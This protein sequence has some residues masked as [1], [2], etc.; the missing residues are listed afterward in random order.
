MIAGSRMNWHHF[1]DFVLSRFRDL[2]FVAAIRVMLRR[3]S[4]DINEVS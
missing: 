4:G 2:H 3:F 1:R